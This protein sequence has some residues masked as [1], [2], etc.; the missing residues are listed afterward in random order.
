MPRYRPVDPK[1]DFP[2]LEARVLAFWARE[3]V[4]ELS[5][6]RRAGAPTWVFYDGPPTANN[7][8]HIGH[9]EART[10]K[11][12]YPRFRTMTGHYVHLK[13]GWDCHGL[14]VE[15]EVEK[16]IGTKSKRDIE[17]FGV[18]EF[19]RLCRESVRRYV[20]DWKR[21]SCPPPW[22]PALSAGPPGTT[23][24]TQA[25]RSTSRPNRSTSCG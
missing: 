8:P 6:A 1:A 25:P 2:A 15:V 18:A 3:R 11:D 14:P 21:V 19:I 9:V 12:L 4:F 17:A 23:S 16:A 24:W 10:F 20:D 7:R 22:M 5:L 13:A